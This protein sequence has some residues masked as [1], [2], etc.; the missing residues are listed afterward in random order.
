M[1]G[2]SRAADWPCADG[3]VPCPG[4]WLLL[5]VTHVPPGGQ[6]VSPW[7]VTAQAGLARDG[8]ALQH[9]LLL[10]PSAPV[11]I[12]GSAHCI[13]APHHP[14]RACLPPPVPFNS[15]NGQA[16]AAAACLP[17]ACPSPCG[18]LQHGQEPPAPGSMG[19]GSALC[20]WLSAAAWAG[21]P[22]Q[23][24]LCTCFAPGQGCTGAG[25]GSLATPG[26]ACTLPALGRAQ[27]PPAPRC[28]L[29]PL[30]DNPF[31]SLLE[32]LP[33]AACPRCPFPAG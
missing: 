15:N 21:T 14:P 24:L 1:C 7:V 3:S 9:S 6:C 20:P 12:P 31:C 22:T 26:S 23:P 2:G 27:R 17:A 19:Q 16:S 18:C 33:G 28:A 4:W 10:L 30:G 8:F 11:C 13:P 32:P 25:Q 29:P 5:G